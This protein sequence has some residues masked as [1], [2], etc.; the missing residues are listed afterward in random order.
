[1]SL[2]LLPRISRLQAFTAFQSTP[3]WV[4]LWAVSFWISARKSKNVES[5]LGS[6]P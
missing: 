2:D 3:P 1:M 5:P 4:E 6:S